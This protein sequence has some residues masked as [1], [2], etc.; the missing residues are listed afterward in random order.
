MR[1]QR[2]SKRLINELSYEIIGAAIEVHKVLGPGLLEKNYEQALMHE[3]QLRSLKTTS[4]QTV[5][6]LY[7]EIILDCELRYDVLVEDL[8]VVEN[9]ATIDMHPV[10]EATVLSYM[11]HLKVPKG[12]LINYHVQ[13]LFKEGQKTF[14]NEFF[15]TLPEM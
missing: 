15:A 14:V 11:K 13:N 1:E 4:Q 10:F 9:K 8:I 2:I 12:I 3:L 7:K 5:E 6:I